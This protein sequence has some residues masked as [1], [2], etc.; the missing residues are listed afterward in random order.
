[1]T[2]YLGIHLNKKFTWATRIKSKTKSLNIRFHKFKHLL[3]S[4]ILLT[5]N[6][7]YHRT[8][9]YGIPL[10]GTAKNQISIHFSPSNQYAFVSSPI[11]LGMLAI[12]LY[13]YNYSNTLISVIRPFLYDFL[14]IQLKRKWPR[15]LILNE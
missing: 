7:L 6:S 13:T 1:M 9:T 14:T 2:I 11:L 15:Y 8:M 12:L 4:N 3:K 5:P 10:W